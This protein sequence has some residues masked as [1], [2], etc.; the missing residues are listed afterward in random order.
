MNK[1]NLLGRLTNKPEIRY[2]GNNI[3]STKFTLAVNRT[4]TKEDGSRETDFISCIA[5]RKTAELI[6]QYF[7]KGSQIGISGKI[8]TGSYDDKDGNKRY[9]TDII[10]EDIDFVDAK[11][12]NKEVIKEQIEKSNDPFADFG[13]SVS[14][15]DNFLD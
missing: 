3:A 4:Y 1:V 11:K 6:C 10:V 5:W 8:Q 13:E 7:D 12:E 2:T 9:T 14:I 15:D